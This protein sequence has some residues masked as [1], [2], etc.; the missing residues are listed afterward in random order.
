MGTSMLQD[1][2]N[3]LIFKVGRKYVGMLKKKM[4]IE[5]L[6]Q[7]LRTSRNLKNIRFIHML[8]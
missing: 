5:A 1:Q 6:Y 2:L 3:R 8:R 7:K 4:G